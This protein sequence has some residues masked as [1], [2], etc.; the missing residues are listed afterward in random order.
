VRAVCES[1]HKPQPVDWK[2]G[3]LCVHCGQPA[4]EQVRCYW[5][6]QYIPAGN[7][8][9]H[10]AA[11]AIPD[12]DYGAA[13]MLKYYGSDMFTIPKQLR[14][15]EPGRL[16]VF[17]S[18]YDKHLGV[19]TRHIEDVRAL[20]K[21]LFSKGWSARLEESLIPQLPWPDD[22]LELYSAPENIGKQSPFG[23]TAVL[24][25]L[26][27]ARNGDFSEIQKKGYNWLAGPLD[28]QM[29]AVLQLGNWRISGNVWI[30]SLR[31]T[32]MNLL[33]EVKER[34][35]LQ[36]LTLAYSGDDVEV[37]REALTSTDPEIYFFA[38]LLLD[39]EEILTKALDS[40]NPLQRMVAANRLIRMKRAGAIVDFFE[41]CDRDQQLD[42][43]GSI[44]LA[45]KPL[46]E[47]HRAL[48]EIVRKDPE[49]P[50]SEAAVRVICMQCSDAEAIELA[51]SNNWR[52][53]H[54][55]A[56]AKLGPE[57]LREI[58]VSL[59][60][61]GMAD[62][63]RME[64]MCFTKNMPPDFVP[65][66]F[67]MAAKPAEQVSL[68]A[69]AEKQLDDLE[70]QPWGTP[71]ERLLIETAFG[72]YAPE[73]IGAAWAAL[74]RINMHREYGRIY[75]FPYTKEAIEEFFP[76]DDFERRVKRL[77]ANQPALEQT[78]VGDDLH[79]FVRSRERA[80]QA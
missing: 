67:P 2:P 77:Q 39:H 46:P 49:T 1:C 73:T 20:E 35:M 53:L 26:V 11:E 51:T 64:W 9:R 45:K 31:Y 3:D 18:L 42:L 56:L 75:P 22:K 4:R 28:L 47:L 50:L 15:M 79:R 41:R 52:M 61:R 44:E 16:D 33:R 54:Q 6:T 36:T 74:H 80:S 66:T 38:A 5:C 24:A 34:S 17:R 23:V 72:D 57:T 12:R 7:F 32:V 8:C 19:A 37:P 13:R 55:L 10:C 25:E 30:E 65:Q 63:N 69:F 78:F 43:L 70:G 21:D 48:M 40:T 14:E 58:G 71:M 59:F 76:F 68:L 60:R 29:E 27:A 62:K